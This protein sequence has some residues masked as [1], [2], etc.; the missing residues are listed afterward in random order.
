MQFCYFKKKCHIVIEGS[1]CCVVLNILQITTKL[2]HHVHIVIPQWICQSSDTRI[3]AA[4]MYCKN[5]FNY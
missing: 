3:F 5:R 1:S 4:L 2:L